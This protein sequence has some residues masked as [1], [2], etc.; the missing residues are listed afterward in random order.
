MIYHFYA[1]DTQQYLVFEPLENWTDIWRG[2]E[3]CLSDISLWMCSNTFKLNKE[4]TEVMFFAPKH[5]VKDCRGCHLTF[6]GNVITNS[7]RSRYIF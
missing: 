3:Y 1:Y 4:N 7:K 6:G 2:L 5:L